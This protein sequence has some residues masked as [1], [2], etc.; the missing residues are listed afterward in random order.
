MRAGILSI[1]LLSGCFSQPCITP[2]PM[3]TMQQRDIALKLAA[4]FPSVPVGGDVE[5]HFMA[6]SSAAFEQLSD[7]NAAYFMSLQAIQCYL[8]EGRAGQ[9]IAIRLSRDLQKKWQ[10]RT[11]AQSVEAHPQAP[12][13]KAIIQSVE[14]K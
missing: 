4:Q 9:L 2:P 5:T 12:E 11:G 6:T 8:R 14:G 10:D 7:D 1:V 13:V 3:S